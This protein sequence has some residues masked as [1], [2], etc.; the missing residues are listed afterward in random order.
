MA[1]KAHLLSLLLPRAPIPTRRLLL[2]ISLPTF[3]ATATMS[4]TTTSPPTYPIRPLPAPPSSLSPP[5][6]PLPRIDET[7][8]SDF[9]SQPRFVTHIDD[10]AISRLRD[11]YHWNL[12]DGAP[13]N[14]GSGSSREGKKNKKRSRILDL[15]T[16]WVSHF[17]KDMETLAVST[18][19]DQGHEAHPSD[20]ELE[21]IGLGM[22][23]AELNANPI[24]SHRILQD[25]NTE[26][27]I[28]LPPSNSSSSSSSS[29]TL[30][31]TTCVVSIDYLTHPLTVLRSI[32]ALT[33]PQGS[34]HLVVSNRCFP[35]KVA[36]EWLRV[37]EEERL[38]MVGRYLWWSGWEGVEV[39]DLC[40]KG[41]KAMG[42][43]ERVF[44]AGAGDPLWVVRGV[45][46]GG[47]GGVGRTEL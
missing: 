1:P 37:S 4:T 33:R 46:G 23:E 19:R 6:E 7:N 35:T 31:A 26:P 12:W 43:L 14:S 5:R 45:K 42:M 18:A 36:G 29:S 40:E 38:E 3:F 28:T 41:G 17:P 21:V 39:V 24:L 13:E 27:K 47:G 9:Y 22:N 34:I 32:H 25:L 20:E 8:D 15:C 44:G 2:S 10:A 11:Y 16:S 30:D